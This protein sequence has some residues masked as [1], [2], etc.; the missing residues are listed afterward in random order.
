MLF[1][2]DKYTFLFFL[3]TYYL[4]VEKAKKKKKRKKQKLRKK[5]GMKKEI[6]I[7]K[8]YQLFRNSQKLSNCIYSIKDY[9]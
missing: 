3:T 7:L 4:V 5:R 9:C 6:N 8:L 1:N 2:T